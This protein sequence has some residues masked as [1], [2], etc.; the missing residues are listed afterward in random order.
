MFFSR[1]SHWKWAAQEACPWA[2]QPT[3]ELHGEGFG[4]ELSGTS[5]R[6]LGTYVLIGESGGTSHHPLENMWLW[7]CC[8]LT[9]A[10]DAML[11]SNF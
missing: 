5:F 1:T 10:D 11:I 6:Q 9:Q 8:V 2:R 3:F 7:L 4:W